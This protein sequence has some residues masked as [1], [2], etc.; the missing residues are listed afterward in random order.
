MRVATWRTL[1]TPVSQ[2][3]GRGILVEVKSEREVAVLSTAPTLLRL[4]LHEPASA[5]HKHDTN[6]I[7]GEL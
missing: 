1:S 5:H 6:R 3:T 4:L 7:T 2:A